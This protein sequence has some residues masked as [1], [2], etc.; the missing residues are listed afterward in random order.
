[1]MKNLLLSTLFNC[2]ALLFV[3]LFRIRESLDLESATVTIG[4][5]AIL[6]FTVLHLK[7]FKAFSTCRKHFVKSNIFHKEQYSACSAI[8][9]IQQYCLRLYYHQL[10][11]LKQIL[12]I[13]LWVDA[14]LML[15][16]SF[17]FW[18]LLLIREAI[19]KSTA[20]LG[21]LHFPI[22]LYT[23]SI[24]PDKQ[25]ETRSSYNSRA[26]TLLTVSDVVLHSAFELGWLISIKATTSLSWCRVSIFMEIKVKNNYFR[27]VDLALNLIALSIRHLAVEITFHVV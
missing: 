25:M 2:I 23:F 1:M 14:S 9:N 8:W 6:K 3:G 21:L 18:K 26:R 7:L 17:N 11:R 27:V 5:R 16:I 20:F 12:C 24:L 10:H 4:M 19:L 22:S 13:L 15:H